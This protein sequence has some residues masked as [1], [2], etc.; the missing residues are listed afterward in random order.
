VRK[1][2]DDR[3]DATA[4]KAVT[5][6]LERAT[7]L[8]DDLL[9]PTALETDA[10]DRVPR[11]HLDALADAGLYGLF[12]PVEAGGLAADATT[13]L[14]VIE[15]LAG[16]CLTTT[17]VWLQHHSALQAVATSTTPGVREGW[18]ERMCRGKSR[19]GIAIAGIRPS[20]VAVSA[21]AVDG[22]WLVTGDVPWVTGW[23]V[24]DVVHAAALTPGGDVVWALVDAVESASLTCRRLRLVAVNASAT[25]TVRFRAHFVP[26]GRITGVDTAQTWATP[27]TRRLR[28]NGS[29]ALGLTAR[30]CRL[31]GPSALDEEL[32]ACRV[33]LDAAQSD[34]TGLPAARAAASL[35][36]YRS[37]GA[38]VAATGSRSVLLD[39]HPQR[40]VREA[41]FLL[42]FGS[43]PPIRKE[44][45]RLFE[46]P[47]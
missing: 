44:L 33:A 23:G 19:A 32:L 11:S 27:E 37:A 30:C 29:L 4:S 43:R 15:A 45:R 26:A 41:A 10:A 20:A 18:L 42:V 38:V 28:T 3:R 12:G 35:L 25:V 40:L 46:Q 7:Q 39:Q 47:G 14:A 16:G 24:I 13:G 17:F 1:S 6:A 8:A 22:G 31:I 2:C 34:P 5:T 21:Q 9:F 36:A